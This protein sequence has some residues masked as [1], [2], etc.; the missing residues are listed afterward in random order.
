MSKHTSHRV[1][2]VYACVCVFN[3]IIQSDIVQVMSLYRYFEHGP[4]Q[5]QFVGEDGELTRE[6]TARLTHIF[7]SGP[8]GLI[9]G[10]KIARQYTI[11]A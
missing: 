7:G 1:K 2:R 3:W 8:P 9:L 11:G 4:D 10:I 5:N 6:S